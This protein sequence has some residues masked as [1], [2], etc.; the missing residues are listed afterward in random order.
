MDV[1]EVCSLSMRSFVALGIEA[2]FGLEPKEKH[3]DT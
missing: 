1:W 2:V 3:W